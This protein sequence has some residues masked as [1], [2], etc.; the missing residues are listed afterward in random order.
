MASHKSDPPALRA[1]QISPSFSSTLLGGVAES[2]DTSS[3]EKAYWLQTAKKT[4]RMVLFL[5]PGA[6]LRIL[7]HKLLP[8]FSGFRSVSAGD[9]RS[10]NE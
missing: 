6:P 8:K 7:F 3:L 4:L 5:D 10:S 2:H 9:H 1:C